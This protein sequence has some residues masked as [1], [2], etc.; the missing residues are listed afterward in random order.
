M[1]ESLC[2][3]DCDDERGVCYCA[4]TD[5]VGRFQRPLPHT[6]QP[7][8]HRSTRLPD[9]R[10]AYPMRSAGGPW[11]MAN[12]IFEKNPKSKSYE[13]ARPDQLHFESLYGSIQSNPQSAPTQTPSSPKPFCLASSSTPRGDTGCR[14]GGCPIGRGGAFCEQGRKTFCLRDCS[15]HGLC[16]D[17][18]CWCDPGWSSVDCSQHASGR[19]AP[20]LQALQE[21]SSPAADHT[22]LRVYVY[23]MPTLF[24]TSLLQWRGS[25]GMVS[26]LSPLFPHPEAPATLLF[27]FHHRATVSFCRRRSSL[28]ALTCTWAVSLSRRRV[29]RARSRPQINQCTTVR[30]PWP[31]PPHRLNDA[32]PPTI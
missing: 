13:W 27:P 12:M 11:K 18:F 24:T 8:A 26:R 17:G 14:G 2:A 6:C 3:G 7:R 28:L 31:W 16:D 22:A 4:E 25:A 10:P 21:L 23:D 9:G 5:A 29:S 30:S 32:S 20:S 19:R 1:R 15:G